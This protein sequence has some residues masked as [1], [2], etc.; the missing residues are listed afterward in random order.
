MKIYVA[1]SLRNENHGAVVHTLRKDGHIVYDFTEPMS[2]PRGF[3]WSDF[4]DSW[5]SWPAATFLEVIDHPLVMEGFR[6]DWDAIQ[7]ADC[8]VLVLP[9]GRSAH[10]EAGYF[11][12]AGKPLVVLLSDGRPELMYRMT[13]HLCLD[14]DEVRG[15]LFKLARQLRP[16]SA[17]P[18]AQ[19]ETSLAAS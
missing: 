11:V 1:S 12:G 13:E 2:G 19:C 6:S 7:W 4:D 5:E 17:I 10:L 18:L 14:L 9:S 15:V 3:H 8:C 16:P